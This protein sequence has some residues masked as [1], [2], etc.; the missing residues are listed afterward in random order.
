MATISSGALPPPPS[1]PAYA[2]LTSD[3]PQR[4]QSPEPLP[5]Y[6]APVLPFQ[7]LSGLLLPLFLLPLSLLLL[8]T[9]AP[10]AAMSSLSGFFKVYH[11]H[12][13]KLESF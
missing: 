10:D 13:Q 6:T 11:L 3:D 12:P 7:Q 9:L 5:Q 1:P 4:E 8:V 2:S